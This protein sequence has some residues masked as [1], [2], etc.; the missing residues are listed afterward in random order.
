M[1]GADDVLAG[2]AGFPDVVLVEEGMREGLQIEDAAIPV[3]DKIRL[4]DALSGTGL[5]RIVVGSFVSPRWTP[6][7]ARIDDLVKGFTPRPGV[8]YTALALN[9][10]GVKRRAAYIPDRL[11]LEDERPATRLHLCDV[12]AQRNTNRTRAAEI[13][14]WDGVV[15]RAVADGA[16]E[17]EIGVNAAWGSNW[18]GRFE[19]GERMRFLEDQHALWTAAGIPVTKVFLGD[20]MGWNM[21]HLVAADLRAIVDRWQQVTTFHL[22]L[23]NTRGMA[24]ISAYA[25]LTTLGPGRRVVL[26]TSV[27]GMAGCPYCGNGRA[28]ALSPTE[29]VVHLL[30]GLGYR[31]GVDLDRL[32]DVVVLAERIVGHPL[33]GHVSK[34][35]GFPEGDRLY[36]MDLPFIETLDEAAHFR[37]GP[38]AYAGPLSPWREPVTSVFRPQG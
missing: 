33:Y 25:A 13:A 5:K 8:R 31:T 35:G 38:A 15:A 20:P 6:Q 11:S 23:H 21:P 22:H 30:E 24:P 7:M 27:G 34:A 26:D 4:L 1:T 18:L 36:P 12:F 28:A 2:P 14:S 19:P 37:R 10:R 17:A 32:I 29:D 3:G 9:A 16:T